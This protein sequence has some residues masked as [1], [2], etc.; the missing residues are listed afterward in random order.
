MNKQALTE[1]VRTSILKSEANADNQKTLHFKR[2]EQAINYA[3]D[4]LLSQIEL[5][6]KGT[7]EIESYF[8]KHYYKQPVRKANGYF[9]VGISDDV[10]PVGAGKGIWYVQP[11]GGGNPL[12]RSQRPKLSLFR[13]LPVGDVMNELFYRYGNVSGSRQIIFEEIGNSNYSDLRNVDYGVVRAVSSY[14]DDEEVHVPTGRVDAMIQLA[15]AWLSQP[16]NDKKNNNQ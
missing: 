12:A 16:Y 4:T 11:T 8:V 7:S 2:V 14:D 5:N 3:F 6:D 13:S 15:T 1:F 9:Y 10:V